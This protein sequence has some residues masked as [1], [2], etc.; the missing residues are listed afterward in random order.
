MEEA[1]DIIRGEPIGRSDGDAERDVGRRKRRGM[2]YGVILRG[3]S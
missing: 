2:R 3:L 1:K